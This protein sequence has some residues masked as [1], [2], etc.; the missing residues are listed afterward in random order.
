[1]TA[2]ELMIGNYHFYHIED[3]MDEREE[4]DEVS[5][6]DY[7]DLRVLT[8]FD[9]NPEY[10]PIPLT[11]EWLFKLGFKRWTSKRKDKTY[12]NGMVIIHERKNGY[13]LA[14]R[15]VRYVYVHQFQNLYF[16]LT[17]SELTIQD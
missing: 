3:P 13:S 15:Y 8:E 4:Y 14:S 5:R 2:N 11:E 16:A 1:M 10:K 7:D 6:I 9:D 12:S 17:G